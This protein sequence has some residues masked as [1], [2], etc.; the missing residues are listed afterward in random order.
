MKILIINNEKEPENLGWIPQ[1]QKAIKTI[2]PVE[3]IVKH[4]SEAAGKLVEEFG[5]NLVVLS[6]RLS[7]WTEEEMPR[8]Q[9]E[10]Q[11][12]RTCTVPLLGICAGHQL[13]GVAFGATMDCICK[14]KRIAEEGYQRVRVIGRDKILEGLESGFTVR[15]HHYWELKS[16]PPGFTLLA[17]TDITPVQFIKDASRPVY[18]VQFH[19]EWYNE[20]YP[21]GKV[22][23]K[24][25]IRLASN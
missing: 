12:A 22:I 5:A 23:L 4:Y 21:D 18:G 10:Y 17:S 25:F 7:N 11:L 16:V 8:F 15:Q 14:S 1:L 20:D 19:P 24:N 3:F 13:L 9:Q 6:G 2:T